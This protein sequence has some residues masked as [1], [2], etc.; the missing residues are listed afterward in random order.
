MSKILT[1][2]GATGT[3]GGSVAAAALSSG[4]YDVRGV[5]RDINSDASKALRSKGVE[6]IVADWN[7]EQSLVKAFEV[8]HLE[9]TIHTRQND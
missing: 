6:M 5:T 9:Y 8:R 3:Q 1:V 7:D 4:K 2:I